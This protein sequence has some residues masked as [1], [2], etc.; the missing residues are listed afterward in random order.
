M[1]YYP[2][3]KTWA[4]IVSSL[5]KILNEHVYVNEHQVKRMSEL[6]LFIGR[7]IKSL[8]LIKGSQDWPKIQLQPIE[9]KSYFVW[10]LWLSLTKR[11]VY[12]SLW[13]FFLKFSWILIYIIAKNGAR[14]LGW[15]TAYS[16]PY[17]ILPCDSS[18]D[19]FSSTFW[20]LSNGHALTFLFVS[21]K[22]RMQLFINVSR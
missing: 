5:F 2:L 9:L 4:M 13:F 12:E 16:N 8:R 1:F 18:V 14:C 6:I 21:F 17:Q 7:L 22:C 19:I 15:L 10:K 11:L 3:F 20:L